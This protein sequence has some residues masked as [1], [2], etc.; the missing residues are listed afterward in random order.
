MQKF[1]CYILILAVFFSLLSC[2]STL[3]RAASK[4]D[5]DRVNELLNAGTDVNESSIS[6]VTPLMR[7]VSHKRTEVVKLLINKGAYLNAQDMKG[8]TALHWAIKNN[9]PETVKLLVERGAN[10]NVPDYDNNLT[11]VQ[12]AHQKG[13]TQI[14]EIIKFAESENDTG[15]NAAVTDIKPDSELIQI[16]IINSLDA[17]KREILVSTNRTLKIGEILCIETDG[18]KVLMSASYPMMT[19]SICQLKG[20]Y[21]KYFNKLEKGMNVYR[22]KSSGGRAREN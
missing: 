5:V 19:S 8:N 21:K 12:L 17:G 15:S 10:I 9:D 2:A 14:I 22:F 1:C 3:N 7:A 4:G 6:S 20:E 13:N 18:K 16:G 11:P